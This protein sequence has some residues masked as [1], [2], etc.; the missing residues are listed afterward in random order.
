MRSSRLLRHAGI[1]TFSNLL[2]RALPF[3]LL[4]IL[5][6]FLTPTDYGLIA[7]FSLGSGFLEPIVGLSLAGAVSVKYFDPKIHLPTY[8][9]SGLAVVVTAIVPATIVVLALSGPLS[10]V[11]Q[12]PVEWLLLLVPVVAMRA[13]GNAFLALLRVMERAATFAL[14][15]NL[16]TAGA[17]ALTILFV[18][19]LGSDWR[20]RANAEVIV[21]MAL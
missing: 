1:Y 7:M 18:V 14:L 9:G 11:T 4:P 21:T 13:I 15:Q 5:T 2:S 12:L 10:A 6:R 8:L 19:V 20:G 3:M 16:Q 17:V